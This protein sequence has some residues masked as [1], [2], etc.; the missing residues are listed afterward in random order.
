MISF[1]ALNKETNNYIHP[2]L[3]DKRDK[4]ICIKCKKDITLRQNK[5]YFFA[6]QGTIGATSGHTKCNIL[7]I[8]NKSDYYECAKILLK[9]FLEHKIPLTV[10][11]KCNNCSKIYAFNIPT[12]VSSNMKVEY[13][14]KSILVCIYNDKLIYTFEIICK[15]KINYKNKLEPWF[16]LDI[17]KLFVCQYNINNPIILNCIRSDR[18][19]D[20]CIN[21]NNVSEKGILYFNQR[22]AGC[23]KTYESIRLIQYDTRFNNKDVY[24]Y[25][26]KMHS[27][28]EVIYSELKK[29]QNDIQ[30]IEV[31]NNDNLI[32]KQHKIFYRNKI[33]NKDIIIII[34]TIDSFNYALVDKNK[35]IKHNEYF[36]GIVESIK[37]GYISLKN[38]QIYYAKERV[39][40]NKKCLVIIDEAQDLNEI[41]IEAFD[42]LISRTNID[43]YII[44]DKLQSIW[45]ENNIYTRINDIKLNT[46]IIRSNEIN[47]VMRFHNKKF[48]NFV[49]DIIKFKNYELPNITKI[50]DGKCKY[51]HNDDEEP[52]NVFKIPK[53]YTNDYDFEKINDFIENKIIEPI[54]NKIKKYNYLPKNFM[55]IFPILTKNT[56]ATTLEIRLQS[57]WIEKFKDKE[58]QKILKNDDFWK[59]KLNDNNFYKYIYLHKSDEGKSINLKESENAS[60]ILSIHASK[61]NGCEVVFLLGIS[62]AVLTLF[63][64]KKCN[65]V[66]DSL[67]HVAITRQKKSIYIGIEYNNDDIHHRFIKAGIIKNIDLSYITKYNTLSKVLNYMDNDDNIFININKDIIE[68]N[69]FKSIF[70]VNDNK[71][72]LIEWGHHTIRYSVMI[73]Y[74]MLNIK[75]SEI[76]EEDNNVKSNQFNTILEKISNK[77][78]AYYKYSDYIKALKKIYDTKENK[79]IPLLV[80][81]N[82]ENTKYYKY[83]SILKDIIKKLK[84]KIQQG[85]Y[86]MP[87]LCSLECV[88]LI[89]LIKLFDHGIY[90]DISI[91]DIYS[92]IYCYDLCFKDI[93][94]NHFKKYGCICNKSFQNNTENNT[95]N[96][97][98]DKKIQESILNHYKYIEHIDITHKN[99]TK[100]INEKFH[101]EAIK[102]NVFHSVSLYKNNNNFKI[103]NEYP[104]IGYS[105][106]YVI[107]FIIK[108]QFTDL[109]FNT[110]M[111]ESILKSFLISNNNIKEANYE[112][113][114]NKKIYTCIIILDITEPIIHELDIASNN[115]LIT[116]IIADYLEITY[117][118][119]HELI[120]NF[121]D[122]YSNNKPKD[123]SKIEYTLEQLKKIDKFTTLPE[124]IYT[125][126]IKINN[127]L[128]ECI[129]E[130]NSYNEDEINKIMNKI[131]NK[132]SNEKLFIDE[133]NI[134][135]DAAIKIYL[136]NNENEVKNF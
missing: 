107:Y 61:G 95:E 30:L 23:G 48:I 134:Y 115:V 43:T 112:R 129:N 6:H 89:F 13:L 26:T 5:K 28:R 57:F 62:E 126:F 21:L 94:D 130:N 74:F 2:I 56:L 35:I 18:K 87:I 69:D 12:I 25:L 36:K 80:F 116:N 88:V 108:P 91:M 71:G 93:D 73:Y 118:K 78:I 121:Y 77:N 41:Y 32:E 122:F 96:K 100:L 75:K 9:Y 110:T 105:D 46:T 86:I 59:D 76:I 1:G 67:L 135:L 40:L 114:K 113:Y 106:N 7:N 31:Q 66:Y 39:S 99:Y 133:L 97:L 124:Y 4:F 58:Y 132:I 11:N 60:R 24:I 123:K 125:F 37:K 98:F 51:N 70:K 131:M 47:K 117:K 90:S 104:I 54:K 15:N 92:I 14:G 102:Y 103:R 42:K 83:T 128:E 84:W 52:I 33:T 55:F 136:K 72:D 20:N 119:H 81:D 109:N 101:N 111:Y 8:A 65:L 49:N 34:G 63:S 17:E 45:G 3:A 64:K 85:K 38:N 22:G 53:M 82:N 50:C 79:E 16:A 68:L 10:N 127:E 44:G 29:Q 120:Y 27:V 19:C